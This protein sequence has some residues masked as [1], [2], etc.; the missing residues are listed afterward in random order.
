MY[1]IHGI[2]RNKG[3][4]EEDRRLAGSDKEAY[5]SCWLVIIHFKVTKLIHTRIT[6]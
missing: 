2:Q 4:G 5:S 3:L 6:T 1:K